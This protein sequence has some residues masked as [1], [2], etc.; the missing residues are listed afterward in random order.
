M[1][2]ITICG[3]RR[4]GLVD[5]SAFS[6]LIDVRG[7]DAAAGAISSWPAR[8]G[9]NLTSGPGA[10][11]VSM[12]AN[13]HR[14]VQFDGTTGNYLRETITNI[15]GATACT[16]GA[17]YLCETDDGMPATFD[18][19]LWLHSNVESAYFHLSSGHFA[20]ET[21]PYGPTGLVRVVWRYNGAG[22]TDADRLKLTR[23]GA[24]RTLTYSGGMPASIAPGSGLVAGGQVTLPRVLDGALVAYQLFPYAMTDAQASQYARWQAMTFAPNVAMGV[25][26]S[27]T[28]GFGTVTAKETWLAQIARTS[29]QRPAGI[30]WRSYAV[31]GSTFASIRA[32][33]AQR[34]AASFNDPYQRRKIAVIAGGINDAATASTA[35]PYPTMLANLDLLIADAWTAGATEVF[36]CALLSRADTGNMSMSILAYDALRAQYVVDLTTRLNSGLIT[37]IIRTDLAPELIDPLN[38]YRQDGLHLTVAGSTA[39]ANKFNLDMFA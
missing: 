36:V 12:Y 6:P 39:F 31:S 38:G 4:G 27:I 26:D 28:F 15:D 24:S 21:V 29:L 35:V 2:M 33:A 20:G 37:K 16:V 32:V 34:W 22:A 5:P 10:T 23:D 11:G 8:A 1:T 13:G 3:P 19:G 18:A 25:G 9:H 14:A 7:D 17:V 30:D